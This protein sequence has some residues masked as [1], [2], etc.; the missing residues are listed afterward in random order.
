M[1]TT[2]VTLNISENNRMQEKAYELNSKS[3]EYCLCGAIT[4]GFINKP[5]VPLYMCIHS[6]SY[7]TL[8]L[9]SNIM[10]TAKYMARRREVG[11]RRN[12]PK[13]LSAQLLLQLLGEAAGQLSGISTGKHVAGSSW[14]VQTPACHDV[15]DSP[16]VRLRA[17]MWRLLKVARRIERSTLWWYVYVE[18]TW[19]P[20]SWPIRTILHVICIP[21]SEQQFE[22]GTLTDTEEYRNISLLP[23][24]L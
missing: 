13:S 24:S 20:T 11:S 23:S 3:S 21:V 12:F 10:I 5:I 18:I 2:S 16:S 6:L 14:Y 4:R 15:R 19:F 8:I 9:C 17:V 1:S 7:T 22:Y